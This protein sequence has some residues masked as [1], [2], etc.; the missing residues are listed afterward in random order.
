MGNKHKLTGHSKKQLR[1][2][3]ERKTV[4]TKDELRTYESWFILKTHEEGTVK[5]NK[6]GRGKG[7][8]DVPGFIVDGSTVASSTLRLYWE[9]L[10]N[11]CMRLQDADTGQFTLMG[12]M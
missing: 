2:I 8:K 6:R 11:V 12:D 7:K 10:E 1:K 9:R 3:I 4:L 5:I